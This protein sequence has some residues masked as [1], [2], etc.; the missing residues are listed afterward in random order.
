MPHTFCT[1]RRCLITFITTIIT[2]I[3]KGLE[4]FSNK[5]PECVAQ[6]PAPMVTEAKRKS[7][8][9]INQT[10]KNNGIIN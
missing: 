2:G 8:T 5:G 6:Q 1:C 9:E 3:R 4:P 7:G 10:W